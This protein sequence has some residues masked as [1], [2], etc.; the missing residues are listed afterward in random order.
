[1]GNKHSSSKE[2]SQ[3]S[4]VGLKKKKAA[5]NDAIDDLSMLFIF[6]SE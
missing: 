4:P 2:K 3:N 5:I 1:M 6:H